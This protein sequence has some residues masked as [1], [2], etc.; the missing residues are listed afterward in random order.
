MSQ[1]AFQPNFESS[2]IDLD[3]FD[4][5]PDN[6]FDSESAWISKINSSSSSSEED[7]VEFKLDKKNQS[8]L[9]KMIKTVPKIKKHKRSSASKKFKKQEVG[10]KK[11]RRL[12]DSFSSSS[13]GG[14]GGGVSKTKTN[15]K[16]VDNDLILGTSS[17]LK[18]KFLLSSSAQKNLKKKNDNQQQHLPKNTS[19]DFNST[20]SYTPN[21]LR[22][23]NNKNALQTKIRLQKQ[24]NQ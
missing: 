19:H 10:K 13:G 6:L 18:K 21:E 7:N 17:N 23:F 22:I 4:S 16:T 11:K 24:K 3:S 15:K 9:N 12:P 1:D 5:N 2:S 8:I 14:G 20:Q